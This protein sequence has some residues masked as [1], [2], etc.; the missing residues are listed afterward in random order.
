MTLFE[1]HQ[2]TIALPVELPRYLFYSTPLILG[3]SSMVFTSIHDFLESLLS[4]RECAIGEK[5]GM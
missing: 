5:G 3:T 2:R 4:L 1:W